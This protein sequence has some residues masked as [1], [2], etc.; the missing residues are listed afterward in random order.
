MVKNI[1]NILDY[2]I[3][4][5]GKI[6]TKNKLSENINLV[7]KLVPRTIFNINSQVESEIKELYK[8]ILTDLCFD[9]KIIIQ[10]RRLDVIKEGKINYDSIGIFN[11]IYEKTIY[12]VVIANN[13][14]VENVDNIILKFNKIGLNINRIVN[15]SEI[16]SVIYKTIFKE[17][18]DIQVDQGQ[19][20]KV[21]PDYISVRNFRFVEI[22]GKYISNVIVNK[23]PS[24][25][26]FCQIFEQLPSNIEY[27]TIFIISRM[28]KIKVLQELMY[29][30]SSVSGEISDNNKNQ[31]D[32]EVL[33]KINSES[34]N[35]RKDIQINDEEV[36]G[37]NLIFSFFSHDLI[38]LSKLLTDFKTRLISKG[39][40][41]SIT[42][43]RHE[44]VFLNTLPIKTISEDLK[45]NS[46]VMTTS[47]VANMF[48]FYTKMIFDKNGTLLGYI[49]NE[50]RLCQ[51]DFFDEKY[52]NANV[53]ILGSSGSGK[54]FFL[55]LLMMR[56]GDNIKKYIFDKEGEYTG[57]V[58]DKNGEVFSLFGK[59]KSKG[60]NIFSL[61]INRMKDQEFINEKIRNIANLISNLGNFTNE[62]RNKLV[63]YL[64]DMYKKKY[65]ENLQKIEE[66][67][68]KELYINHLYDKMIKIDLEYFL[69]FIKEK[70]LNKKVVEVFD[71]YPYINGD[72]SFIDKQLNIF[73]LSSNFGSDIVQV[74][75]YI[76]NEIEL[77]LRY[78]RK[79]DIKTVIAFDEIFKYIKTSED[80]I[81]ISKILTL[82]KTIRKK[83]AAIITVT[84]D[85]EDFF[86]IKNGEYGKIVMNNSAFK[87]FFKLSYVDS[88]IMDKMSGLG[89]D[90]IKNIKK[91][92]K[93]NTI[94]NFLS[95]NIDIDIVASD[96]EKNIIMR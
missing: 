50:N 72:K 43:F 19:D 3:D 94:L 17:S 76:L 8:E 54:S 71:K 33:K 95:N 6:H 86:G 88:G 44:D 73:D 64:N 90:V 35:L 62:Q 63:E 5:Y 7:Y 38:K 16:D 27:D 79:T 68:K 46:I 26:E 47:S 45:K 24:A 30:I 48:P 74:V 84:Q 80:D 1:K 61:D 59:D 21:L 70:S 55:K 65:H 89:K 57:L 93:S 37:T 11:D 29:K 56:M 82:Y 36:F 66:F 2:D 87:F 15:K 25:I 20:I 13:H 23:Y 52:L 51:I 85:I 78:A 32:I 40:I 58:N 10:N 31:I 12:I 69:K 39:I 9:M 14:D 67:R 18:I 60:I 42:N 49:K 34:L 83:H 4:M 77:E 28:D 96:K 53:C 41:S 75:I 81:L 22:D 92:P 91:L